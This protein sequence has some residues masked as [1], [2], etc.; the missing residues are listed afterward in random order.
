MALSKI[1]HIKKAASLGS[2]WCWETG[3]PL[4]RVLDLTLHYVQKP[5]LKQIKYLRA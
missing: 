3:C 5:A 2:K 1:Q 4:E